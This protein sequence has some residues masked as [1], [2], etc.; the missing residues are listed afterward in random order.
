MLRATTH[1]PFPLQVF[2]PDDVGEVYGRV[3][4][5]D[6]RAGNLVETLALNRIAPGLYSVNW[7]PHLDGYYSALFAFFV[8]PGYTTPADLETGAEL[9]EV[10]GEKAQLSRL[11][12]LTHENSIIDQ[13][14]YDNGR[15][16]AARL[17][18]YDCKANA[19]TAGTAGLLHTW[20]VVATYDEH[21]RAAAYRLLQEAP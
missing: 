8:D 7:T 15:L 3:Q 6:A 17:R 9:L 5:Y 18:A 1:E 13:Q 14:V 12:G 19:E 4:V 16:I 10:T 21:G 11:L 2:L 20:T